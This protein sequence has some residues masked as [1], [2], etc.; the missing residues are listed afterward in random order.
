MRRTTGSGG[1]ALR[2]FT[3]ASVPL[4]AADVFLR[5]LTVHMHGFA[6]VQPEMWRAQE[7]IRGGG[8]VHPRRLFSH[9]Y[10]LEQVA[11]AYRAFADRDEGMVK[12]AIVP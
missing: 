7:L 1:A 11:E 3:D 8:V 12:V 5:D 9:R 4:P 6:N 2:V 10:S